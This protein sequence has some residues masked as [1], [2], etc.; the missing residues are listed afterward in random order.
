MGKWLN[1]AI[2][3]C[4]P[5]KLVRHGPAI[6]LNQ[7]AVWNKFLKL[8]FPLSLKCFRAA[9]FLAR[10]QRLGVESRTCYVAVP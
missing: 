5:I 3:Q 2:F 1:Q 7:A 8:E 6:R 9:I 10:I 4:R